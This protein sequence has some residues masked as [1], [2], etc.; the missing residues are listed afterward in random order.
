MTSLIM[1]FFKIITFIIFIFPISIAF[2][3][4]SGF[5]DSKDITQRIAHGIAFNGNG[6][7]MFISGSSQ[8][9]VFEFDLTLGFDVSTA[10]KNSNECV[11]VSEQDT[12]VID[13]KFNSDGTKLFLNRF[14]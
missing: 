6:T 12:D 11:H 13:L 14:R 1:K 3:A 9:R 4:V 2:G 8:N 7:K 10:T 5:V